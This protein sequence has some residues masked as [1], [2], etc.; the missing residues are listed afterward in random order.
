MPILHPMPDGV[1]LVAI[2]IAKSRNEVLIEVPGQN[3][4]RR[5]T[6]LNTRADHDRLIALLTELGKPVACAFEATGNYHRPIAWRLR[7]AGFEIRLISQS[8]SPAPERPCTT[9][10]TRTIRRMRK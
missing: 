9:A 2:D 1:V 3:R 8:H 6:V 4:R 10:G 5:L 7:E